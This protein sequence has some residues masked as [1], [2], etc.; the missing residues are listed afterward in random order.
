MKR[1]FSDSKIQMILSILV[2]LFS[3]IVS[4]L[5][6]VF[7]VI[8]PFVVLVFF[9][10]IIILNYYLICIPLEKV[11][12]TSRKADMDNIYTLDDIKE[13]ELNGSFREIWIISEDLKMASDKEAFAGITRKNLKRGVS[14]RFYIKNT[15]LATERAKNLLKANADIKK[16]GIEFYYLENSVAFFDSNMDYDLFITKKSIEEH[17][18]IGIT[19]NNKRTYITMPSELFT[20][21]KAELMKIEKADI[22]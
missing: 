12:N 10:C 2:L 17:G 3:Y 21:L 22:K 16:A 14:Y 13:H 19:I 6:G 9:I 1:I 4:S 15:K 11:I 8:L 20:T 18:F 5:Q 7:G